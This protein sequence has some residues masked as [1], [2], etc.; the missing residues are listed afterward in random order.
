MCAL[1]A[2]IKF[3]IFRNIFLGI[4]KV[5]ISFSILKKIFSKNEN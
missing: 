3:S 5:V 4:E 1:R 2:H